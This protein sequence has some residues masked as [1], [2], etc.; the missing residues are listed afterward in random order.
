[1]SNVEQINANYQIGIA[2]K[3]DASVWGWGTPRNG[4]GS[5]G[6][7]SNQALYYPSKVA[8]NERAILGSASELNIVASEKDDLTLSWKAP[9]GATGYVVLRSES[10]FNL[11]PEDSKTYTAG[12]DIAG[13]KVVY[14]GSATS[15]ND[16]NLE[17]DKPYYYKV[18]SHNT[19]KTYSAGVLGI[20]FVGETHHRRL[21][22]D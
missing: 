1:M 20:G 6:L 7:G 11:S 3:K 22:T 14:S 2:L 4:S 13:V 17:K 15:F 16:D 19:Y 9:L 18:F 12:D 21:V 8:T 5:H 10:D